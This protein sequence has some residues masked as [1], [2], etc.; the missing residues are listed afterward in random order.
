MLSYRLQGTCSLFSTTNNNW[1]PNI[2]NC[3]VFVDK[4]TITLRVIT[5]TGN[6]RYLSHG[7]SQDFRCGGVP[8]SV[9]YFHA[10]GAECGY[11]LERGK[12][13]SKNIRELDPLVQLVVICEQQPKA[14]LTSRV[15]GLS[16]LVHVPS[17]F[18]VPYVG[19][20]YRHP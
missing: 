1:W 11:G 13:N 16:H 2:R 12:T 10:W 15:Q 17:Q 18:L 9:F 5:L 4:V 14:I 19:M 6:I 8:I 7:G 3:V 20:H